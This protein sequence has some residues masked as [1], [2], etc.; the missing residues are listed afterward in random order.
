MIDK[1]TA[2]ALINIKSAP[3][4]VTD[5]SKTFADAQL[6]VDKSNTQIEKWKK[7]RA[8]AQAAADAA[9][10]EFDKALAAWDPSGKQKPAE[11]KA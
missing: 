2:L 7:E 1:K 10:E 4:E 6:R 9:L 8:E 5:A 11:E 3:K